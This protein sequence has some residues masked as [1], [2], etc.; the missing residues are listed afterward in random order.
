MPVSPTSTFILNSL[1]VVD[2]HMDVTRNSSADE[3]ANVNFL[4]RHRT[5][6]IKYK[7]KRKTN[8]R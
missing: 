6:T 4:Q 8:S 5:R 7:K 1:F 3:I 2:C